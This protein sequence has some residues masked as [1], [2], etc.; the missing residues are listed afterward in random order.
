[1]E[2]FNYEQVENAILAYQKV[3]TQWEEISTNLKEI[4]KT[5]QSNAFWTG[6][7]SEYFKTNWQSLLNNLDDMTLAMT[8]IPDFLEKIEENYQKLELELSSMIKEN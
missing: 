2:N 1:M 8:N 7:S 4:E 6:S 3:S 5:L